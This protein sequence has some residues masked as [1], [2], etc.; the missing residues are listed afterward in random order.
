MVEFQAVAGSQSG[1]LG[2]SFGEQLPLGSSC[3][4][5]LLQ[6]QLWPRGQKYSKSVY[7]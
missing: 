6:G 1:E 2:S 3:Q 5:R 4:L 7:V